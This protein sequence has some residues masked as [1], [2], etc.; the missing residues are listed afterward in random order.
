MAQAGRCCVATWPFAYIVVRF[1]VQ[2]EHHECDMNPNNITHE[3]TI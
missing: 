2:N 3:D 1:N